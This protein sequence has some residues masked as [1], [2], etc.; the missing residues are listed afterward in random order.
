MTDKKKKKAKVGDKERRSTNRSKSVVDPRVIKAIFR[1]EINR[2]ISPL[3]ITG[4]INTD[5]TS[6][7]KAG[8]VV[9]W[10][11]DHPTLV[12]RPKTFKTEFSNNVDQVFREAV[13]S[14]VTVYIGQ[15]SV[16]WVIPTYFKILHVYKIKEDTTITVK[17]GKHDKI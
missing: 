10:M 1:E 6:N 8:V 5:F 9:M 14:A 4:I 3:K 13:V 12:G 2:A 7:G 17:P 11:D 15:G 16:K